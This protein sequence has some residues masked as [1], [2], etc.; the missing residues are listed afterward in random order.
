MPDLTVTRRYV[1]Y[2]DVQNCPVLQPEGTDALIAAAIAAALPGVGDLPT[3]Y[4]GDV[5]VHLVK[6][7][8]P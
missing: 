3:T 7:P 4:T 6:N 8:S 1:G 2:F 5:E